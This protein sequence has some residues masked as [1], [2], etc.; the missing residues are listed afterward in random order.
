MGTAEAPLSPPATRW[1]RPTP[2]IPM[3]KVE[4]AW[5]VEDWAKKEK[6]FSLY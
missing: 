3:R 5:P 6:E 4:R 2:R 1:K